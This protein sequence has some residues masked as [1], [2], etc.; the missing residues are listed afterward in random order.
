MSDPE[1]SGA[2]NRVLGVDLGARRIGLAASDP[3]GVLASPVGV[4]E[5]SGDRAVEHGAIVEAAQT[6]GADRLVVGLP[7]SL[8]GG[9]GPAAKSVLAEVEELREL[10]SRVAITV[11]THDERFTTTIAERGLREAKV[12]GRD[13]RRKIDAAAA[14]VILQSWLEAQR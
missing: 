12:R 4:I 7:R 11:E 8:S 10:A 9:M 13:R 1:L 2:V 3:S 5:R 6:A 14:T